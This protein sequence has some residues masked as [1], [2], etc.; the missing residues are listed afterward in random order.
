MFA[1]E[2]VLEPEGAQ[3]EDLYLPPHHCVHHQVHDLRIPGATKHLFGTSGVVD[4]RNRHVSHQGTRA[5]EIVSTS[6]EG[7][8]ETA[9]RG[10]AYPLH[11]LFPRPSITLRLDPEPRG[12][13]MPLCS[14]ARSIFHI[15]PPRVHVLF[16]RIASPGALFFKK[17]LQ[18]GRLHLALQAIAR[19]AY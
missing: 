9:D 19:S 12:E 10:G 4:C 3:H 13:R 7:T 5:L 18:E 17:T 16:P 8:N 1:S 6:A 14:R 2:E 11:P 15:A